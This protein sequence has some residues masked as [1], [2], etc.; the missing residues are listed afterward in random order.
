MGVGDLDI[1]LHFPLMLVFKITFAQ[2]GNMVMLGRKWLLK[3]APRGL[4]HSP[5]SLSQRDEEV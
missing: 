4:G 3:T 5:P 1:I 2:I